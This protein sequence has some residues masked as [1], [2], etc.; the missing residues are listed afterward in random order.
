MPEYSR[1]FI[2]IAVIWMSLVSL[3]LAEVAKAPRLAKPPRG[4]VVSP[5]DGAANAPANTPQLPTLLDGY[6]AR[7]TW[8]VAGVDYAVGYASGTTLS[9][10]STISMADVSVDQVNH[11]INITGS[12]VTLSGYDFS[13]DGGWGVSV[14][15]GSNVT[16]ENSKFVVGRNGKTPIYVSQNASNVTIR[17]NLIDGAGSSA[18]ILV[19]VNGTGTTIIQYNMIQNAWGQ[20]VVM[21]SDVGGETWIVQYNVIK[22][23]GLGFSQG[24]HGDW[25]QTYNLPGKNTADLEV[26]FN[27][28]V[29]TAPISAGRTQGISAFSANNGSDAGGVQTESFNNNTFIAR[30]GA[31][32]NYGIILDTTRLIG[33][34][35]IRNNSF[36]TTNIGSANGGGG[37]WQYVGNYNGAN[38]GPYRGVVTQSNNVNMTTGSYFNQRGTSIREVVASRSGGSAGTGSTVNLTLEFSAPVKVTVSDKAPTLTLSDGGVATYTGGSGASGLIFSYAVA[39]G[40]NAPLLATAINLNGA[41]VKNSVGQVVDLALAGIPQTGPQISSSGTD[42]IRP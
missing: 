35:T 22:D 34:A 30:N 28:F 20:N 41:T 23:A 19:G 16:I 3:S 13:L 24:A 5:S 17:N 31:Y 2:A 38:G 33:S 11:I 25:I 32:V 8:S 6:A 14:N 40:Q 12:N 4:A 26:N 39:S 27:T 1:R 10:P 29:Q 36:D 18:Q 21:S 42:Q 7:P 37:G 9:N 15:G